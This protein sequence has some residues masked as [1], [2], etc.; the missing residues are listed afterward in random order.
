MRSSVLFT[1]WLGR[2]DRM[3]NN[4]DHN[5]P[6]RY[7]KICGFEEGKTAGESGADK[8]YDFSE[9]IPDAV[10]INLGTN[11]ASA[12]KEPMWR[13]SYSGRTFKQ[14]KNAMEVI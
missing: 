3:D 10:I 2:A 4:P 14:H 7:E 8:P 1:E 9:W 11:D 6:S 13:D 5:V 12:F